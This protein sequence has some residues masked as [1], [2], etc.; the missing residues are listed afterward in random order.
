MH[1]PCPILPDMERDPATELTQLFG[2]LYLHLHPRRDPGEYR[3]S[4]ESLAVLRHLAMSGPLAVTEA[5]KH[6]RRSQAAMSELL[7]RLIKRDLLAKLPDE[8]DRRRHVVWLTETGQQLVASESEPL[9]RDRVSRLL[10]QISQ[11]DRDRVLSAFR[12]L[13]EVVLDQA[14][15]ER[16]DRHER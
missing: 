10:D 5:A 8:R 4:R 3:P 16:R 13:A 1:G 9:D 12:L 14:T 15:T 11:D 2:Q 7:D 6:F